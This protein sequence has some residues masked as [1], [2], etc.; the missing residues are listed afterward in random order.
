MLKNILRKEG[1]FTL[2]E[3]LVVIVVL[4]LLIAVAVPTFKSVRDSAKVNDAKNDV[5][6]AHTAARAYL[7]VNDQYANSAGMVTAIG[8]TEPGL[9]LAAGAIPSAL[10]DAVLGTVYVNSQVG[11]ELD[12]IVLA[13]KTGVASPGV[14]AV[15]ITD[16][17]GVVTK[18]PSNAW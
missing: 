7:A 16:D 10:G 17:G 2:I 18:A 5:K 8:A 9:T 15:S 14:E 13:A 6:I 1:G 12:A 4:G 11:G 3:L